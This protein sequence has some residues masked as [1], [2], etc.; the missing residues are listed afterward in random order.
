MCLAFEP[1]GEKSGLGAH[2]GANTISHTRLRA[3]SR[4]HPGFKNTALP[5]IYPRGQVPGGGEEV[6]EDD[7]GMLLE[8]IGVPQGTCARRRPWVQTSIMPTCAR[9]GWQRVKRSPG[10]KVSIDSDKARRRNSTNCSAIQCRGVAE[11]EKALG[12]RLAPMGPA[13]F[14]LVEGEAFRTRGREGVRRSLGSR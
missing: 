11:S 13:Q 4:L 5:S 14:M 12:T 3:P 10:E 2:L 1:D 9:S 7:F 6:V 8:R